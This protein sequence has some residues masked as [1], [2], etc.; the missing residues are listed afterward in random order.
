[1]EHPSNWGLMVSHFQSSNYMHITWCFL[2]FRGSQHTDIYFQIYDPFD[3]Y[4][5]FNP[6]GIKN[7]N[8]SDI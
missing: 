1:M 5:R 6:R 8:S 3:V 2:S 7:K 4:F